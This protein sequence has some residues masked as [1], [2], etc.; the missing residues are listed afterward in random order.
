MINKIKK[1]WTIFLITYKLFTN[2]LVPMVVLKTPKFFVLIA[3]FKA[4]NMNVVGD[5]WKFNLCELGKKFTCLQ[6]WLNELNCKFI[7]Y[8]DN[9]ISKN[10]K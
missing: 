6:P 3:S 4:H 5:L 10:F 9:K 2:I 8:N 1:P 7:E